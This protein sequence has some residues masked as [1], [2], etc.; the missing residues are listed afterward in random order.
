MGNFMKSIVSGGIKSIFYVSLISLFFVRAS[1]ASDYESGIGVVDITPTTPVVTPGYSNPHRVPVSK[2][3]SRLYVKALVLALNEKRVAIVTLDSLKYPNDFALRA[4]ELIEKRTGI[5]ADNIIICASHTHS[6]P[7]W[8]YYKDRLVESISDA[9]VLANKNLSPSLIEVGSTNAKKLAKTRR[10]IKNNTAWNLWELKGAEKD[11]YPA[12]GPYDPEF[13]ILAVKNKKKE[14]QAIVYNFASHA[15]TNNE[16]V[17]S[18]DFPGDVQRVVK[19]RLGAKVETFY[20]TGASGN[21]NPAENKKKTYVGEVLARKIIRKL[22]N[23]KKIKE[24]TLVVE[25]KELRMRGRNNPYFAKDDIALKEPAHVDGFKVMFDNQL[26]VAKFDYPFSITGIKISEDFAI[27][28]S[29]GE[30]FHEY[31]I[32][33][34][35]KSKFEHTMVVEQTNGAY[36]YIPTRNAF[37]NG[38]YETWFG[39]HSFLETEA[40]EYVESESVSVLNRLKAR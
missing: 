40:G 3:E 19:A 23:L 16:P 34:K 12:E 36:G 33:I 31:G 5:P 20:L 21:I 27:V 22:K 9:V 38:G 39:T 35:R 4:R 17:I 14:L 7:R 11:M 2:V 13:Q 6:A 32:N 15:T 8:N 28:T 18:A 25:Y 24:P 10:V 37:T 30:L 1:M 29:P 26:K